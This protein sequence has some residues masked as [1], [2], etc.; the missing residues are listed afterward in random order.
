VRCSRGIIHGVIPVRSASI[1]QIDVA[2]AGGR[3]F[4]VAGAKVCNSQTD[5]VIS[6]SSLPVFKTE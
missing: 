5:D 6:T 1:E 4:P 2:T 3:A